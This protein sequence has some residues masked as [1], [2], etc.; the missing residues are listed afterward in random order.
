M[1]AQW[2]GP[3]AAPPLENASTT[4]NLSPNYQSKPGDLGA[5][6]MRAGQ[7][8]NAAG[9]VCV[10]ASALGGGL[11]VGQTYKQYGTAQRNRG[12][13]YQNTTGSPIW[14]S[15]TTSGGASI[16][17]YTAGGANPVLQIGNQDGDS[18]TFDNLYG[19]I[20]P[21]GYYQQA[22]TVPLV[23]IELSAP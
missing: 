12:I 11:G 8:C 18:G 19:I 5:I 20:P 21:G 22:G 4:I 7:Y 3:T 10:S 6:R 9:T 16:L 23:W 1:S 17:Y 14:V 13:W 15:I 2:T